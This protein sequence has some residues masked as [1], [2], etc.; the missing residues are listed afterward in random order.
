MSYPKSDVSI[1]PIRLQSALSKS[2]P[3]SKNS[4][5][6]LSEHPVDT[7]KSPGDLSAPMSVAPEAMLIDLRSTRTKQGQSPLDE[8]ANEIGVRLLGE[9]VQARRIS[10]RPLAQLTKE[11]GAK[12]GA[13]SQLEAGSGSVETL[14]AV[15]C[16]LDFQM[17]GIASGDTLEEQ[18]TN[19]REKLK[20]SV[21]QVAA[22]TRLTEAVVT[23]LEEGHGSIGDLFRLL[24]LIAP[25]VRRSAPER[26]Y[27]GKGDKLDRDSRF[28]PTDFMTSVYHAFGPVDLDPCAHSMSPVVASRR[29]IP[30]E[31]GDGLTDQWSGRLAFVNAP[32]SAQLKWLKRAYQQWRAGHVRTVVCLL[33]V[34][35]DNTFFHETLHKDADLF[36]LKG[37]LRF[38]SVRGDTQPTPFS[39]WIVAL[40]ATSEQRARFAAK[41]DGC[42]FRAVASSPV[43]DT[44]GARH[45]ARQQARKLRL[46]KR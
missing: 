44:P 38:S 41:V 35:T 8:R 4:K 14:I 30:A 13:I 22:R 26:V 18:L 43:R 45:H 17:A 16:A 33:P 32:Y 24:A 12:R 39:L 42:W 15:M 3:S 34:R 29:I 5:P 10:D 46:S 27:W 25:K 19:R 11:I 1:T 31:G 6:G 9:L 21:E 37:R 7:K 23:G 36:L 28:T 40:G 2:R 20:L